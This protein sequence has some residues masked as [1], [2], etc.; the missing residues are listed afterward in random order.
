MKRNICQMK[1]LNNWKTI[2]IL[3]YDD[4]KILRRTLW[5][6]FITWR[7]EVSSFVTSIF[8]FYWFIVVLNAHEKVLHGGLRIILNHIRGKFWICQG[9]RV[10]NKVLQRCVVCKPSQGRTMKGLSPPDYLLI[11][12][13]SIM[14]LI[15]LKL[16][17]QV[18]FMLKMFIVMA[19][20]NCL[21]FIFVYLYVRRPAMYI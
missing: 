8:T 12:Y 16:I 1:T 3:F 18:L 15:T 2:L 13:P 21:N 20:T 9:R 19:K 11:D 14:H 6:F 4:L 17:L 10:V 7:P 5:K